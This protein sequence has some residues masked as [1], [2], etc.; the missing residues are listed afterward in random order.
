MKEDEGD[1]KPLIYSLEKKPRG[2]GAG[3][4]EGGLTAANLIDAIITSQISGSY[5]EERSGYREREVPKEKEIVTIEDDSHRSH[6]KT[7]VYS[8]PPLEIS[9]TDGRGPAAYLGP[10]KERFSPHRPPPSASHGPTPE[11]R[12]I[13]RIAQPN[14]ASDNAF[15]YIKNKIKEIWREDDG[16]VPR[17]G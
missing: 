14:R 1:K 16:G 5:V 13:I 9:R 10:P 2:G 12:Q 15:D 7:H 8:R 3:G 6:P 17:G 4:P 11:E